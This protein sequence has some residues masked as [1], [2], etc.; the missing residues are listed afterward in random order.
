MNRVN[1][2]HSDPLNDAE[3]MNTPIKE[4]Q[5]DDAITNAINKLKYH[6][7]ALNFPDFGNLRS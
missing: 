7:V 1:H 5:E 6:I 4:E 3:L 2:A